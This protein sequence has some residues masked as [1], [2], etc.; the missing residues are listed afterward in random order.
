MLAVW[1]IRFKFMSLVYVLWL[2]IGMGLQVYRQY[3]IHALLLTK[4]RVFEKGTY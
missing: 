2:S 1:E 3:W 4:G